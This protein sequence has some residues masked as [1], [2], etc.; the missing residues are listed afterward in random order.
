MTS[1][2]EQLINDS[3][4]QQIP[5]KSV[6]VSQIVTTE[7]MK[8]PS[9]VSRNVQLINRLNVASKIFQIL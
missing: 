3:L 7:L 1:K 4:G 6:T 5:R 2:D 8:M 9:N